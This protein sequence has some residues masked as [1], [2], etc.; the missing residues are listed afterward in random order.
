MTA[1]ARTAFQS[2]R[3]LRLHGAAPC[4]E[5]LEW[6]AGNPDWTIEDAWRKCHRA[7]W[8]IWWLR[9]AG[10]AAAHQRQLQ[11]F[12][13]EVAAWALDKVEAAGGRVDLRSRAVIET[14]WKYLHDEIDPE[15]LRAAVWAA[16]AA[17]AAAWADAAA[18]AAAWATAAADAGAARME[19]L[20]RQADCLRSLIEIPNAQ[21]PAR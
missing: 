7:D 12:A 2:V 3:D 6:L 10:R 4:P 9:A 13:L 21:A 1:P 14:A 18:A 20:L 11:E 16:D 15:V 5:A 8:M 19:E 17:D